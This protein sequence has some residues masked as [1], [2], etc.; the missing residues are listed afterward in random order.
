MKLL[1]IGDAVVHSGFSRVTH[2]V[3]G[4]LQKLG[5]DVAVLGIIYSGDPHD[6]TYPIYTCWPEHGMWDPY[7]AT[8]LKSILEIEQPDAILI[9]HDPWIVAERYIASA[10]KTGLPLHRTAA[11][12][13]VDSPII[14]PRGIT[15]LND[16]GAAIFY[17]EFGRQQA[18]R[19]GFVGNA[20]V[21]PHGVDID[22]YRPSES[23]FDVRARTIPGTE[24]AFVVGYVGRNQ[25]RKRMDLALQYFATWKRHTNPGAAYLW[26]H[27]DPKDPA[28]IDVVNVARYFGIADALIVNPD[29][30]P[31]R[32]V[33]EERMPDVYNSL[34]VHIVTSLGEGWCL[35]VAE[36]M[37]CGVPNIVPA[38]GGLQE[39]SWSAA[40][41]VEC[42][43]I[44][45]THDTIQ[46]VPDHASFVGALDALY[47]DKERREQLGT[48]G[49]KLMRESRFRWSEVAKA[50][51]AVLREISGK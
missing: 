34:D 11:Y 18:V 15:P 13:P 17:T 24:G 7:G 42:T 49:L 14:R 27:C 43:G 37:A 41:Q 22:L 20:A 8:K 4:E 39:W 30:G 5:W 33:A 6:Y 16:L 45:A 12:M 32:G 26:L 3:L 9:L 46:G 29:V 36:A 25:P 40:Q 48:K 35:P 10:S 51:D 23:R 38:W 2:A 47:K 44:S 21:I 50:F 1:W 31:T 19:N 28:G